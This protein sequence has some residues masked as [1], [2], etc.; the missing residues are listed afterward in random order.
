MEIVLFKL[1][2]HALTRARVCEWSG[3]ALH[4]EIKLP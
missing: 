4:L 2:M 1:R 3:R